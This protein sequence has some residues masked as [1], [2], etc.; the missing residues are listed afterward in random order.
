MIHPLHHTKESTSSLSDSVKDTPQNSP[1]YFRS[2]NEYKDFYAFQ[3]AI[4]LS[5]VNS[6]CGIGLKKAKKN[7]IVTSSFPIVSTLVFPNEEID[8]IQLTETICRPI[9]ETEK[10][11][12]RKKQTAFRRYEKNK[13]V[14]VQHLLMDILFEKGF[15]FESKMA[16]NSKKTFRLERIER[17]FYEG[18]IVMDFDDFLQRG[19]A[20]NVYL[21]SLFDKGN[22][23]LIK[24]K[25][26]DLQNFIL[27]Q[28]DTLIPFKY[29]IN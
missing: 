11:Q 10:L 27:K 25:D 19:N 29:V 2:N 28:S 9:Y 7:T 6:Y 8:V 26:A 20:I 24:L 22:D 23:I 16:R 14:F 12:V 13:K 18:K 15:F 1:R 17:I 5:F 21:S 4:L 3:Q